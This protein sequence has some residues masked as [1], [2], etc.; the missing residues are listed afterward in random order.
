M[1]AFKH[2]AFHAHFHNNT[3]ED[4]YKMNTLLQSFS[5]SFAL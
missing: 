3:D 2:V 5:H 4:G 1:H